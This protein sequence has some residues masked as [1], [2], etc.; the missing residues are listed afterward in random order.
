LEVLHFPQDPESYRAE[1]P[2]KYVA[3]QWAWERLSGNSRRYLEGLPMERR[4]VVAG[5]RVL[6]THCGPAV[7]EEE[8]LEPDT[9]AERFRELA[10]I[11][12]AAVVIF[13]HSHRPLVRRAGGTWF[14]NPGSVGR[15]ADGD[16]RASYAILSMDVDALAVEHHR[17]TYDVIGA[18]DAIRSHG[19]PEAFAQMLLQG[20]GLPDVL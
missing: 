4:F 13:G 11:A 2:E 7:E 5:R 9:S 20:R 6:L 18:V 19:L 1:G 15:P 8:H 16:P 3:Y 10:G 17:V 12:D 14:I